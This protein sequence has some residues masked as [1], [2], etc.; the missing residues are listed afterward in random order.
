M[1]TEVQKEAQLRRPW[2][3]R[4]TKKEQPVSLDYMTFWMASHVL[5]MAPILMKWEPEGGKKAKNVYTKSSQYQVTHRLVWH[6]VTLM[7][8]NVGKKLGKYRKEVRVRWDLP[9]SAFWMKFLFLLGFQRSGSHHLTEKKVEKVFQRLFLNKRLKLSKSVF[10]K[11]LII[12]SFLF[13][14]A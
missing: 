8:H 14:Q 12:F 5:R 13:Q 2:F 10:S 9:R 6:N 4:G 7:W 3:L 1:P 11:V